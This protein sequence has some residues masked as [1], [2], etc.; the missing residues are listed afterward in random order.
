MQIEK[1]LY[2]KIDIA[3]KGDTIEDLAMLQKHFKLWQWQKM[4]KTYDNIKVDILW[5]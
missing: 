2:G 3:E 5:L 4:Q 1:E